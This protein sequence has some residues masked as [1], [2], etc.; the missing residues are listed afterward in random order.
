MSYQQIL[1]QGNLTRDAEVRQVGQSQVAKIGVAVSEKY[2]TRDGQIQE[3]T[4]FFDVEIW[5]KAGVYPYL[6]K[7]QSVL[8]VGQQK[9]D[10]WTD[11]NGQN[12]ESK[13]VRAQVVQLC[14]PRPQAQ[15]QTAPAQ[16]AYQRPAPA[17]QAP[18]YA[19]PAPA[20]QYQQP[21]PPPQY[22]AP[23]PQ[24]QYS[25]PAPPPQYGPQDEGPDL[26]F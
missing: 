18:A 7:G 25:A 4:E 15:P 2:K 17:P 9:T 6:V 5:D 3:S 1:I 10:K 13:R 19:Q 12:R 20:P 16:A 22:S 23:A 26:P 24:P 14:G 21:A 8:I 11:Q